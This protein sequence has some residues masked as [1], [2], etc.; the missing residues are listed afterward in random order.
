MKE[1]QL[2]SSDKIEIVKQQQKKQTLILQKKIIPCENHLV[3]E[4]N[5]VEK[6]L[7]LAKYEPHRTEIHYYEALAMYKQKSQKQIDIHNPDTVSK[8][9]V[10]Q[11]AN[12]IYVSA[13]NKDNAIKVLKRDYNIIF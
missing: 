8:T 10:I 9:K 4:F 12:C 11:S 3:F 6:T 5:Y 7:S 2:K 1:T 13:M